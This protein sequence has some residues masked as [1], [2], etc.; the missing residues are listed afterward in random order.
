MQCAVVS[1][2]SVSSE[3]MQCPTATAPGCVEDHSLDKTPFLEWQTSPEL[4]NKKK[5][6]RISLP[7]IISS[8]FTAEQQLTTSAQGAAIFDVSLNDIIKITPH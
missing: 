7:F 1:T 6:H 3:N 4:H 5:I 2:S 8:A